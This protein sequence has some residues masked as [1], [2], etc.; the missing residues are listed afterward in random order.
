M[1]PE[2]RVGEF[3]SC[4]V[5]FDVTK[6]ENSRIYVMVACE[7]DIHVKYWRG[8]RIRKLIKFNGKVNLESDTERLG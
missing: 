3:I 8:Y 2:L 7:S 1:S 4:I 6:I 5:A